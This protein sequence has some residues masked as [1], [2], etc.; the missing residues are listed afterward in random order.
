MCSLKLRVNVV[1][2]H[3]PMAPQHVTLLIHD[4]VSNTVATV[5]L[6]AGLT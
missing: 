2:G 6:E 5:E 4:T 3:S 1:Q